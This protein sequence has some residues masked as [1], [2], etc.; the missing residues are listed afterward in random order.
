MNKA[1]PNDNFNTYVAVKPSRYGILDEYSPDKSKSN[2]I[3]TNNTNNNNPTNNTNNNTTNNTNNN[4]PQTPT[5]INP[6]P[7]T[8]PT[9]GLTFSSAVSNQGSVP[10]N[11][12]GKP[13]KEEKLVEKEKSRKKEKTMKEE[14]SKEHPVYPSKR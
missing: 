6:P 1:V 8:T 12:G 9:E 11:K 10:N 2:P 7:Y 4:N 13:R 5:T 3:N 14:K